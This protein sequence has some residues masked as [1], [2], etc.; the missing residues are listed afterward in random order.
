MVIVKQFRGRFP[1]FEV[2]KTGLADID[3]GGFE[4]LACGQ[5]ALSGWHDTQKYNL[6]AQ[7]FEQAQVERTLRQIDGRF[8]LLF[9]A[10]NR[11]SA[12]LSTDILGVSS[13]YICEN[14][15]QVFVASHLGIMRD[16]LNSHGVT[17]KA[18]NIGVAAAVLGSI[19]VDNRT[20][21]DGVRRL[22]AGQ[23]ATIVIDDN[24][25][26]RLKIHRYYHPYDLLDDHSAAKDDWLE[27][28][29]HSIIK[30]GSV[31]AVFLTSG[32]DSFAIASLIPSDVRQTIPAISY[33][34]EYSTDRL[35]GA[36]AAKVLGYQHHSVELSAGEVLRWREP[37]ARLMH[38]SC[39]LQT[40]QHFAGC[41]RLYGRYK[42]VY[43]GFLGDILSGKPY[44][45][46]QKSDTLAIKRCMA[47]LTQFD[48]EQQQLFSDEISFI[49]HHLQQQMAAIPG[50]AQMKAV[51]LDILY[52]QA[53]W[54]GGTFE[55]LEQVVDISTPFFAKSVLS[56]S[57]ND[58]RALPDKRK[59]YVAVM[60]NYGHLDYTPAAQMPVG[61]PVINWQQETRIHAQS[62][63]AMADVIPDER[64]RQLAVNSIDADKSTAPLALKI[65]PCFYHV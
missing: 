58:R 39:G 51:M 34:G 17:I 16:M 2:S 53:H 45:G 46:A 7:A 20:S 41:A 38:G 31:A 15:G 59:Q 44:H 40:T 35:G 11:R 10:Q 4:A 18:D 48:G 8:S 60:K 52:R 14:A 61:Y 22:T 24:G 3:S 50:S 29:Q 9:L 43:S 64:W 28:L 57:L 25:R 42:S 56:A 30:Q 27:A 63:R 47:W 19:C 23:Y 65:L 37:V 1:D 26:Q 36:A 49:Q 5:V 13:V 21:I 12:I 54:I 55:L 62:L 32:F 33:G 6:D